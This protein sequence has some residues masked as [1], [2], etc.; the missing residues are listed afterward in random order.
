M[1]L[2]ISLPEPWR[3]SEPDPQPPT[4]MAIQYHSRVQEAELGTAW[5]LGIVISIPLGFAINLASAWVYDL[6]KKHNVERIVIDREEIVVDRGEIQRIIRE[7]IEAE[8]LRGRG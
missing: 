5:V 2:R 1:E 3:E 8:G 6:L 4:G 7:R